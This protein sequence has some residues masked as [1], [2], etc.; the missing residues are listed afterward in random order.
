MS[1]WCPGPFSAHLQA[2]YGNVTYT[3]LSSHLLWICRR[4]HPALSIMCPMTFPTVIPTPDP[5][6]TPQHPLLENLRSGWRGNTWMGLSRD[7]LHNGVW[8]SKTFSGTCLVLVTA[9]LSTSLEIRW[10]GSAGERILLS[11]LFLAVMSD[12]PLLSALG[13]K[14]WGSGDFKSDPLEQLLSCRMLI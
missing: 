13:D 6:A 10:G 7:D 1:G 3:S 5:T 12:C 11:V 8:W 9:F 14:F 4:E 2:S